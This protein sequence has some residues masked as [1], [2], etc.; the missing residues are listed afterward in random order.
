[1][2]SLESPEVTMNMTKG[3]LAASLAG[4]TIIASHVAAQGTPPQTPPPAQAPTAGA[5][6]EPNPAGRGGR[7]QGGRGMATFPAQ[8]RPPG[9]PEVIAKGKQLFTTNCVSCHGA[10]LRGGVTGG[11]NLLR[12]A[13]VLMDEHGELILP[14]VHGARAERG[15]PPLP[16]PDP[17]V[18][19]IAEYIHS[20][21]STARG[22]GAPPE[23]ETPPP[24]A[25]VGDAKAGEVYFNAKCTGCHSPTGDL[26]GI[27][28]RVDEAKMLQNDW[29]VGGG[30]GGGRGGR[31]GGGRGAAATSDRRTVTATVTLAN[32]EKVSGQLARLDN[33]F[34]TLLL[35]DGRL[36][37]IRREGDQ[38]KVEVKDPL[39]FH[40]KLPGILTDKDMH[41]VTAY[42]AT[43]K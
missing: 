40:K 1:M 31:G 2:F 4:F 17:D 42:L 33:F 26:A 8:Q 34:V 10:D 9:D 32:G 18:V 7:G 5:P 41:D 27:G 21:V 25:L 30:G 28:S 43:L 23:T 6:Q 22:Q 15:M 38:P 24:N 13:V 36:R 14:I 12:S 39:E 11:P 19:A 20:V 3:V 37:T 35:D 29:V 16:L